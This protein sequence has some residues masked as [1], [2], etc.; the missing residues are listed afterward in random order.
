MP[1]EIRISH[2]VVPSRKTTA[3]ADLAV[4]I[5][6]DLGIVTIEDCR[7]LRNRN[8]A[9]WFSPPNYPLDA[10]K[11]VPTVRLSGELEIIV[12]NLAIIE[13]RKWLANNTLDGSILAGETK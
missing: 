3:L 12:P 4:E 7:I 8:G 13:F 9:F 2:I 10:R 5:H 11:F 6:T 1:V